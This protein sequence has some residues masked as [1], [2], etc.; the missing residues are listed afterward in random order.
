MFQLA[1]ISLQEQ[2]ILPVQKMEAI[3]SDTSNSDFRSYID[4][5]M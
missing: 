3:A 1:S 4:F 2:K 5:S